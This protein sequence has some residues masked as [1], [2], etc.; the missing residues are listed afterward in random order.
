MGFGQPVCDE[1]SQI[2]VAMLQA[3]IGNGGLV[4]LVDSN[5]DKFYFCARMKC[6]E[7]AGFFC[8]RAFEVCVIA[9]T[10]AERA[11]ESSVRMDRD[12]RRF[13]RE[14]SMAPVNL[15]FAAGAV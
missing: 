8:K 6:F 2:K 14:R 4:E 13:V 10:D 9:K 7:E 1:K 12:V 3:A 11:H 15:I 5:R